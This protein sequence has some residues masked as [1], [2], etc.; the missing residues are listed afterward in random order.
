MIMSG[1]PILPAAALVTTLL[2]A[3]PPAQLPEGLLPF[4]NPAKQVD[5]P[6]DLF[7]D[8]QVML[9]IVNDPG[10]HRVEFD[11]EGVET[12]DDPVWQS[13]HTAVL[14]Q[15]FNKAAW[16]GILLRDS[17]NARNRELAA[18]GTFF[19]DDPQQVLELIA[20]F[21]GEPVR[22]IREQA[23]RRAIGYLRVHLAKN[24]D[25]DPEH[26]DRG[27]EPLYTLEVG[28]YVALLALDDVRDQAQ[29]YWFL[30]EICKI[31]PESAINIFAP[32]RS[33]LPAALLAKDKTLRRQARDFLQVVDPK[34]RS[35]PAEDASDDEVRAWLADVVYDVFPP[36]RRINPGRVDLF[37]S[38]D[39]DRLVAV[40][41][42]RLQRK[43]LGTPTE[44]A[45]KSGVLFRG[46]KV[47]V[48]PEPLNKL[49]IPLGAVITSINGEP[50]FRS[51]DILGVCD[52][53]SAG[54]RPIMVEYVKNREAEMMEYR[55]QPAEPQTD[56]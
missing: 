22:E 12:C 29:G 11:D 53:L 34:H 46:F 52:R 32:A 15:M 55:L 4:R 5:A 14:A 2:A 26:P 49:G 42:D 3:A 19:C 44:G 23:Y 43:T 31:R 41:R 51:A 54:R 28:P 25:P 10:D 17:Q 56:R 6:E 27:A 40:G 37:P 7:R 24:K 50:V 13:K 48:L 39:L 18:Y 8:L 45:L 30:K 33:Y 21:P 1:S 35:P 16:F 36:I 47:T 20:F 9:S 38:D